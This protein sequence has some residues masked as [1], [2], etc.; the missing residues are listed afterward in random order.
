MEGFFNMEGIFNL[1]TKYS[2]INFILGGNE[3]EQNGEETGIANIDNMPN[4]LFLLPVE[5][6][7]KILGYC[8]DSS[9]REMG[10]VNK[11]FQGL[12]YS[13]HRHIALDF[14]EVMKK[15]KDANES[16][17]SRLFDQ[18]LKLE[19]FQDMFSIINGLKKTEMEELM[20]LN[21]PNHRFQITNIL[22]EVTKK[23]KKIKEANIKNCG[24]TDR[25]I[26]KLFPEKLIV[27][28][29]QILTYRYFP[30]LVS[31]D[32]SF[33]EEITTGGIV[34]IIS[35]CPELKK[36]I[37]KGLNQLY[38]LFIF[39]KAKKLEYLDITDCKKV[40][41]IPRFLQ[42]KSNINLKTIFLNGTNTNNFIKNLPF[43]E[44]NKQLLNGITTFGLDLYIENT[45][46][47]YQKMIKNLPNLTS[48]N[49]VEPSIGDSIVSKP[50]TQLKPEVKKI[51]KNIKKLSIGGNISYYINDKDYF[52]NL[53]TFYPSLNELTI[54]KL[55]V[56][57]F[58]DDY[59]KSLETSTLELETLILI[60]DR[61]FID[62][63]DLK[64]IWKIT[65]NTKLKHFKILHLG[66][67]PLFMNK[68]NND[69]IDELIKSDL[70]EEITFINCRP[71]EEFWNTYFKNLGAKLNPNKTRKQIKLIFS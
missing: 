64:F 10:D 58:A 55:N 71:H 57:N 21:I 41:D 7:D 17:S 65:K 1:I 28:N 32:I 66:E 23:A 16:Q 24:L 42:N 48:L 26:K 69:T 6:L 27:Q 46:D 61:Y 59:I 54:N 50:L 18:P 52:K 37:G 49:L 67:T 3:T 31:I 12:V 45:L 62:D 44:Q 5:L 39:E 36:F 15:Y 20:V 9:L 34:C 4:Y 43:P 35:N 25:D 19:Y 53:G 68:N 70:I 29:A 38:H 33:N 56:F 60:I 51:N 30:S 63:F 40:N 8:D 22:L 2:N 14:S 11:F 47:D 13:R